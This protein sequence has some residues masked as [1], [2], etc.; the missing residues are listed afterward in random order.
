MQPQPPQP[1][2]F[3]GGGI[4]AL[5]G[6]FW[7]L[8]LPTGLGAGLAAGGL[9]LLL[10]AVQHLAWGYRTGRF[11]AAVQRAG[12][13]RILL[14]L[15]VAGLVV[16]LYRW[17]RRLN[18]GGHGGELAEAIWFHSGKMPA[19]ATLSKAV[20][21]IVV[22]G[23]G[24]ALG[25][26]A[27]PKQT[28]ATIAGLLSGLA[29]LAPGATAP[30]GGL[31]RRRRHG[32]RLQRSLR[33][34][35]LRDRGVARQSLGAARGA[36]ARRLRHRDGGVLDDAADRADLY[37]AGLSDL[38]VADGMGARPRPR[39]RPRRDPLHSPDRPRRRGKAARLAEAGEPGRD[40]RGLGRPRDPVPGLARQRQGR[41]RGGLSR[42]ARRDRFPP[43]S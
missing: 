28:G 18:P 39:R 15:I 26:E 27:A 31:R 13:P 7:L 3:P 36:G 21:S 8:L 34:R 33:R 35:A 29:R 14:V 23:M 1:N 25:R 4:C 6:R 32:R 9:M 20:L 5:P 16:G 42:Q 19:L 17:L 2:L 40:V 10:H 22:V 43:W 38:G 30:A 41:R 12:T 24:A 37:G 11:L